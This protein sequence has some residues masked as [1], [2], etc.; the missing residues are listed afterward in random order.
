MALHLSK[1]VHSSTGRLIMSV[2]LG[3][4]LASF[5]RTVCKKRN[6]LVFS[7]APLDK[8]SKNIYKNGDKCYSYVAHATK[9]TND[10][11]IIPFFN[12][13]DEMSKF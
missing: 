6:C 9:C 13:K 11:K 1:F 2:L 3:F 4:G 7:A 10:K 12:D 5:F 8:F